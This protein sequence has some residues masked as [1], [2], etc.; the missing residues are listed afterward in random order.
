LFCFI[1]VLGACEKECVCEDPPVTPSPTYPSL[2]VANQNTDDR[3]ITAVRFVGYDFNNLKIEI[4]DSQTFILDQGMPG[5]YENINVVVHYAR[6]VQSG[7]ANILVNFKNDVTE[8][9]TLKGCIS[10]SGCQGFYLE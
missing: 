3:T 7:S 5:G 9:V 4:G 2:R 8:T 10:F 1:I 6:T